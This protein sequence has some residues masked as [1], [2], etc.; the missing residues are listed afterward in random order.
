M[1]GGVLITFEAGVVTHLDLQMHRGLPV[2]WATIDPAGT[3]AGA[4]GKLGA[5]RIGR[6]LPIFFAEDDRG[7]IIASLGRLARRSPYFD[8]ACVLLRAENLAGR[9]EPGFV[10]LVTRAQALDL[11][12]GRRPATLVLG[13]GRVIQ[14]VDP[15]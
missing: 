4:I 5:E 1:T 12:N 13:N 9:S 10:G 2:G 15:I 6:R 3:L 7:S 8:L 11:P 14:T